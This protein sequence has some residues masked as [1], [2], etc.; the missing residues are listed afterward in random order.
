VARWRPVGTDEFV[1]MDRERAYVGEHSPMV[2]LEAATPHGIQQAGMAIR[3]GRKYT[4]RVVLAAEPG[5]EVKVAL[6]WGTG[7]GDRQTIPIKALRKEYAK[8]P[9]SFTAGETATIPG[10]KSWEPARGRSTSAPC[11]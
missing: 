1:V 5:A 10:S 4:G 9:L 8:F 11:P 2:K 7:P 3:K 6:V